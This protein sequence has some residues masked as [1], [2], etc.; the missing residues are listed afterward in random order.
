M[1]ESNTSSSNP[2]SPSRHIK[3]RWWWWRA[4]FPLGLL[5]AVAEVVAVYCLYQPQYEASALLEIKEDV[6][7]IAF[8]PK[9][10]GISKTYFLSQIDIIRS[11]WILGRTIASPN[12][13]DLP[14]IHK[15][16]DPIEW[17]RKRISVVRSGDSGVFEIKYASVS[18]ESSALVVNEVTRQYLNAQ[19]EEQSRSFRS[20]LSALNQQ[21]TSRE[22]NVRAL[23]KQ[24]ESA[25]QKDSVD[26]SLN[27]KLKKDE[28]TRAQAVLARISDR[29]I[30]LQTEQSAPPRVIWHE[31]AKVLQEPVESMLYQ[32]MA[33]A[34]VAGFSFPY[35]VGFIALILWNL[36]LLIG[37]LEPLP[38]DTSNR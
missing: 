9:E 8:Q 22:E 31:P 11:H 20:I 4:A 29:L 19:E 14:E 32:K 23:R 37:K 26:E 18:P 16:A 10:S 21:L 12:I 3:R 2:A 28:L 17:L 38:S 33:L 30:E 34:A 1:S 7:Y 27:L 36:S 15:Q 5:L 13:K 24:V 35:V 6:P 25:M